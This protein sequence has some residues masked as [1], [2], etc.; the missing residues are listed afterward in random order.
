MHLLYHLHLLFSTDT[1]FA[2]GFLIKTAHLSSN[3]SV[4]TPA[5][6]KTQAVT[7]VFYLA[8]SYRSEHII[9]YELQVPA[10]RRRG[11]SVQMGPLVS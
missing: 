4:T 7:G 9:D 1:M 6:L 5:L 10:H 11:L 3:V 8:T 2:F